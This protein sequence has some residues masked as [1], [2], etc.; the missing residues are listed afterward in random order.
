MLAGV[1]IIVVS[2]VLLLYWFRY[3]CM[4]LLRNQSVPAIANPAQSSRFSFGE[5]QA[6]LESGETLD[7]LHAALK[8]DYEILTFLLEHASGLELESLEDRLLV[9]DYKL[10]QGWY[11]VTRIA[12]P[13]LARRALGEMA[14]VI[15]ILAGR[16]G[17]RA[18]LQSQA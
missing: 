11:G 7:P 10:M 12:A 13:K 8:R 4:L 5:V 15:A 6:R 17:E 16:M 14:S 1:L 2:A 9:L 3:T 18:G